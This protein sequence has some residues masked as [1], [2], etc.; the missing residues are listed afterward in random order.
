MGLFTGCLLASDIDGTLMASGYIN[1][2]NIK[3]I[4]YFMSEGGYFSLSTG[5]TAGAVSPVTEQL[6]RFSPSVVANG[7]M[8]YDFSNNSVLYEKVLPPSSLTIIKKVLEIGGDI[9]I[10]AH[11]G[12]IVLD[13]KSTDETLAHQEYE[14][15]ETIACSYEDAYKYSLNKLLF[16]FSNEQERTK[17]KE[18][19]GNAPA[20]TV[21]LDTVAEIDG[22]K[23]YYYELL[24]KGV[25]KALALDKLTEILKIDKGSLFA[26]G[27]YYNDLEMI[28]KADIG[29]VTKDTPDDIK[30]YA[31]F[32]AGSCEDGAVADFIDY[33][34]EKRKGMI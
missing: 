9:G 17:Y 28:K 6:K 3:K 4:E 18:I 2:R 16:T 23:R 8:I 11:N 29:A 27:D 32:I 21:F 26:I 22:R 15:L 10:E 14:K 20:G 19:I 30:A 33:L 5:R 31:D 24:P 34:T 7:C 13:I 1:P 25:S 12:P